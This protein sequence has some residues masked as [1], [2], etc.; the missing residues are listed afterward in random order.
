ME[1]GSVNRY[2]RVGGGVA[3][4]A[5]PGDAN[6]GDVTNRTDSEHPEHRGQT[7]TERLR[8]PG[9]SDAKG[10]GPAARESSPVDGDGG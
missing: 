3:G 9:S 6:E 7:G 10:D 4:G 2:S 1:T 5:S 8:S